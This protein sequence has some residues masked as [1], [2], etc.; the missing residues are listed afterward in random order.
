M[1]IHAIEKW[2]PGGE[3]MKRVTIVGVMIVSVVVSVFVIANACS[4]DGDSSSTAEEKALDWCVKYSKVMCEKLFDCMPTMAPILTEASS[5]SECGIVA[6]E[7]CA[8]DGDTEDDGSGDDDECVIEETPTEA[9]IQECLDDIDNASCEELETVY[10]TGVCAK[11]D[12]MLDCEDDEDSDNTEDSDESPEDTGDPKSTD[13]DSTDD[14]M[15]TGETNDTDTT[16]D[17]GEPVD[18]A[19]CEAAVMALCDLGETCVDDL[20]KLPPAAKNA[21]QNCTTTLSGKETELESACES[22]LN[23]NAANPTAM[24]TYLTTVDPNTISSCI[25]SQSCDLSLAVALAADMATFVDTG[26]SDDLK[27][28]LETLLE[29]CI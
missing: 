23:D 14:V 21:F 12:A 1:T 7:S 19:G 13:V 6:E 5:K 28:L 17:T 22:Y 9:E 8:D 27:A 26:N 18:T 2:Q 16:G 25:S 11:I 24:A 4:S 29:K 10:S 3:D 15:D 20:P